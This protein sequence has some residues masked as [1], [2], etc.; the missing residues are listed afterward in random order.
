M[1]EIDEKVPP[2]AEPRSSESTTDAPLLGKKS[3]GVER[4]EAI[5]AHTTFGDRI[6]IFI[7]VFLIAYAYG[8][9]GTLR[10]TYQVIHFLTN[11]KPR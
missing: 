6:A 1:A 8:L 11:W 9:D 10:Y 7:G 4:M 3:P 2:V 5:A